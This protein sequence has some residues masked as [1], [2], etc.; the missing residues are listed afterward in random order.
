MAFTIPTDSN[1]VRLPIAQTSFA[2]S[3]SATVGTSS[4]SVLAAN[5][6]R[7]FLALVNDSDTAIYIEFGGAASV[8]D[9]WRLNANGG[10]IIFDSVVPTDQIFAISASASKKLLILEG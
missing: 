9:G 3:S 7:V 1:N 8:N 2:A 10:G 5:T 4:A 6:G